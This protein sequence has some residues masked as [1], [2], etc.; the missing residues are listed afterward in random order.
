MIE[1]LRNIADW[2]AKGS[3]NHPDNVRLRQVDELISLIEQDIK[4]EP[5]RIQEVLKKAPD[6]TDGSLAVSSTNSDLAMYKD[7][8]KWNRERLEKL[9]IERSALMKSLGKRN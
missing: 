9:K 7:I 4:L 6:F 1:R 3:P 8:A 5:G 2:I